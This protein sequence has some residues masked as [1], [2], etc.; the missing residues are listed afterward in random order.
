MQ[1]VAQPMGGN[2]AFAPPLGPSA[3]FRQRMYTSIRIRGK[4]SFTIIEQTKF[5]YYQD[6]YINILIYEYQYIYINVNFCHCNYVYLKDVLS[7][8]KKKLNQNFQF[9]RFLGQSVENGINFSN[10]KAIVFVM[11]I[12]GVTRGKGGKLPPPPETPEIL[13]KHKKQPR[14][15]SAIRIDSSKNYNFR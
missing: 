2:R 4:W 11:S 1:S 6:I 9:T 5:K 13:Q 8:I 15:K 7:E 10:I 14:P 3:S 12:S